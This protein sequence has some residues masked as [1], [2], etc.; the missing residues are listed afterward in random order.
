MSVVSKVGFDRYVK[1]PA[2]QAYTLLCDWEDQRRWSPFIRVV[3]VDGLR[4]SALTGIGPFALRDE[5]IVLERDD[6]ARRVRVELTGPALTGTVG[7]A[8]RS[9]S[10][11]SCIVRWDVSV[12]VP[13]LSW[14]LAP[15]VTLVTRRLLIRALRRLHPR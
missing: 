10:P 12:R 4:F 15:L 1:L 3:A 13:F 5:L 2:E 11:T 14:P 9:F 6:V 8:V 7:F